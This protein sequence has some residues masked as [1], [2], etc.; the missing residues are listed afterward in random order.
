MASLDFDAVNAHL[1]KRP[2]LGSTARVL[3]ERND[4]VIGE[5][6]V[7]SR[8]L[9]EEVLHHLEQGIEPTYDLGCTAYSAPLKPSMRRCVCKRCVCASAVERGHRRFCWNA[10]EHRRGPT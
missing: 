10:A 1:E 8:S 7:M 9:L 2:P 4:D 3:L 5:Q 6:V